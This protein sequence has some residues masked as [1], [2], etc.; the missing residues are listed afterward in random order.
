MKQLVHVQGMLIVYLSVMFSPSEES[1][2]SI[3][4][5]NCPVCNWIMYLTFNT[6]TCMFPVGLKVLRIRL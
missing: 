3:L 4:I 6:F 5:N 2:V 1:Y